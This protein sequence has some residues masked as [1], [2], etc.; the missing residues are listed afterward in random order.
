MKVFSS[1][2]CSPNT[3][4]KSIDKAYP[5]A[6]EKFIYIILRVTE[7]KEVS[8]SLF[9][10]WIVSPIIIWWHDRLSSEW[11]TAS[12]FVESSKVIF[13][14]WNKEMLKHTT[15]PNVESIII[16][17]NNYAIQYLWLPE[18]TYNVN[19]YLLHIFC[20]SL[21]AQTQV[22]HVMQEIEDSLENQI[23]KLLPRRPVCRKGKQIFAMS[24]IRRALLLYQFRVESQ[25][26]LQLWFKWKT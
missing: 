25:P 18:R 7:Y 17:E 6:I 4:I 15:R 13:S 10:F 20:L 11:L 24:Y 3:A 23:R 1:N 19:L 9:V 8:K 14:I 16:Y 21:L 2:N 26:R 5:N 22:F 12:C